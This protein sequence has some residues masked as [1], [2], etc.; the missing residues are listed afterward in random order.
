MPVVSFK[1]LIYIGSAFLIVSAAYI[2]KTYNPLEVGFFPRC[3]FHILTGFLCPGCGSQ[4]ALHHLLNGNIALALDKNALFLIALPYI[5]F[6]AFLD[7]KNNCNSK[8]IQIRKTL[9]GTSAIW[10]VLSIIIIFWL[11]RNLL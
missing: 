11:V 7:L 5:S 6:G 1:Q 3:P 10:I 2:Y 4:R 8:L 9:Y